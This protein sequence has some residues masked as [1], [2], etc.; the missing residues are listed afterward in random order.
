MLPQPLWPV[1]PRVENVDGLDPRVHARGE[2]GNGPARSLP[3]H[4]DPALIQVAAG[5]K[6]GQDHLDIMNGRRQRFLKLTDE[7]LPHRTIVIA[8]A[9]HCRDKTDCRETIFRDEAAKF[10]IA[11]A[12]RLR[13]VAVEI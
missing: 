12:V 11:E 6:I 9:I 8:M 2:N 5:R 10:L 1:S 7:P 3:E 4:A 13:G